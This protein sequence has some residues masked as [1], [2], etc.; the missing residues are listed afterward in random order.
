MKLATKNEELEDAFATCQKLMFQPPQKRERV[1]FQI[2]DLQNSAYPSPLNKALKETHTREQPTTHHTPG[3]RNERER[4]IG[5]LGDHGD[6]HELLLQVLLHQRLLARTRT[7]PMD[8]SRRRRRFLFG[9]SKPLVDNDTSK[10]PECEA[11]Q[12]AS[13]NNKGAH[14]KEFPKNKTIP[15]K[16]ALNQDQRFSPPCFSLPQPREAARKLWPG[17]PHDAG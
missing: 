8:K 1:C 16:R 11:R 12:P 2:G 3:S 9:N 7:N 10:E 14:P 5:L 6:V 13:C 15:T 17:G 4:R